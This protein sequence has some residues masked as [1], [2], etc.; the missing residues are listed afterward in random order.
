MDKEDVHTHTHTH[1]HTQDYYSA[2]KKNGIWSTATTQMDLQGIRLSE[3]SQTKTNT[4]C[5]YYVW[6]LKNKTNESI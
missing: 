2:I 6:K 1:T 5:Y 4:I 3:V